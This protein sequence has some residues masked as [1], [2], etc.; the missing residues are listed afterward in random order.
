MP[1]PS[2]RGDTMT[3]DHA[4]NTPPPPAVDLD[5]TPE[6]MQRITDACTRFTLEYVRTVGARPSFDLDGA[7][8][9]AAEFREAPPER[10]VPIETLLADVGRAAEKSFHVAGPGYLAFIPGGGIYPAALGD[11]IALALN[12]YVGVWNPAPVCVQIELTAI[13][14]IRE[15]IGYPAGGNGLLTSG[16][17]LSNLIAIVTAR[18]VRLPENFLDGVLYASREAHHCIAKSALLAGFPES[19]VH[20]IDVDVRLRMRPDALEAAIAADRRRGLRP[21]L[22]VSSAGTTNTG[23]IDPTPEI[24]DICARHDLWLHV[25]AAYG[26]FFRMVQG[27][28]ELLPGLEHA[29]SLVLDPHKGMFL[30]YGTGCLLL[31][32]P[33]ALRRAHQLTA[34]YMQDLALPEGAVN[35]ADISPE[36]SRDFRGLRIWLP[37][38]LYGAA[39]FRDNL[40]EKLDL[41]RWAHRELQ[42]IPGIECIDAPQLSVAAFRYVPERGDADAFNVELL[43]RINARRRV[44][45]TSTRVS[46]HF[47]LRIAVLSFRTHAVHVE[48]AIDDVRAALQEMDDME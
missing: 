20:W 19:N 35:F 26:G 16:G 24:A 29:D 33:D 39:A 38:K 6:A 3:P 45:L 13:D 36:L 47:V 12:R 41:A 18:R 15:L 34:D 46:G 10:G 40:Q 31:R 8:E 32:D 37:L 48:Q 42:T 7:A 1:A 9:T 30:P 21:F 44:L 43:R 27:G 2:N 28:R 5:L 23:A 11:Y 4:R 22:V 25:D 14:W 17:S